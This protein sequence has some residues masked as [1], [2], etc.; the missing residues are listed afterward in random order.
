MF[1]KA[2][3]P[4]FHGHGRNGHNRLSLMMKEF[5]RFSAGIRGAWRVNQLLA[6][7]RDRPSPYLS[8]NELA[9]N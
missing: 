2:R 3:P 5:S 1:G 8:A 7:S 4:H 9:T 6:V